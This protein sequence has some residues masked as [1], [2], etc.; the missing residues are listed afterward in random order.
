ML[1]NQAYCLNF[2]IY[3]AIAE[4]AA[5]LLTVP[6]FFDCLWLLRFFVAAFYMA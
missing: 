2:I 6:D 1:E 5:P 4:N 3:A